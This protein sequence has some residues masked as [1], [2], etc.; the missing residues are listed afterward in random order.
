MYI[1]S[2]DTTSKQFNRFNL[3]NSTNTS[4]PPD[5]SFVKEGIGIMILLGDLTKV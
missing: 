3:R 2:R 5:M 4:A 1:K